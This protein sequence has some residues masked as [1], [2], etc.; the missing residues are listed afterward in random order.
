[1]AGWEPTTGKYAKPGELEIWVDD[2]AA[3]EIKAKLEASPE[4]SKGGNPM[5]K[6]DGP[7]PPAEGFKA[8][9]RYYLRKSFVGRDGKTRQRI[10]FYYDKA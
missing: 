8:T 9:G 7:Q 3:A 10:R 5:L 2:P 6:G 4:K 1:M